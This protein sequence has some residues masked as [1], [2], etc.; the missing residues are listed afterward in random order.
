MSRRTRLPN[1]AYSDSDDGDSDNDSVVTQA[2]GAATHAAYAACASFSDPADLFNASTSTV[3]ESL[4]GQTVAPGY[5]EFLASD[6]DS[7]IPP[8]LQAAEY[9]VGSQ[10]GSHLANRAQA[11]AADARAYSPPSLNNLR[12]ESIGDLTYLNE[13]EAQTFRERNPSA[14]IRCKC[15][16]D[17]FLYHNQQQG[18]L[19]NINLTQT[20]FSGSI[21]G[22]AFNRCNFSGSD[23]SKLSFCTIRQLPM[24][25][26]IIFCNDHC[27]LNETCNFENTLFSLLSLGTMKFQ[28]TAP[29]AA[30]DPTIRIACNSNQS[31]IIQVKA[32]T[33]YYQL[34][35]INRQQT[36]C[37]CFSGADYSPELALIEDSRDSQMLDPFSKLV[38]VAQ[39]VLRQPQS[40]LAKLWKQVCDSI[41][42]QQ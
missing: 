5:L 14:Y 15:K 24:N 12:I 19:Q 2:N 11:H 3:V 42:A 31:R 10:Y 36:R 22:V 38:A 6:F 34:V 30:F 1:A 20:I 17:H 29:L 18:N 37:C 25:S 26:R 35:K 28:K 13:E 41:P 27:I 40:N 39:A 7:R 16:I 8:E 23:L 33:L 4:P 32:S 21:G 9:A